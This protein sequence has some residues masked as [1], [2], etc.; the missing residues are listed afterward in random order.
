M[1][2]KLVAWL[3]AGLIVLAIIL[4]FI[5]KNEILLSSIKEN[6]PVCAE[7]ALKI[8]ADPTQKDI[9]G[10]SLIHWAVYSKNPQLV[11]MLIDKKADLNIKD[12]KGGTPLDWAI[13]FGNSDIVK[14]LVENGAEDFRNSVGD[15][16]VLSAALSNKI[17]AMIYLFNKFKVEKSDER[18]L[19][20][21]VVYNSNLEMLKFL[22]KKGLDLSSPNLFLMIRKKT[23]EKRVVEAMK[24][25]L[26]KG[27]DINIAD[28][29]GRTALIESV[30]HEKNEILNFLL[31]KGANTEIKDK[32]D[33]TAL[34]WAK[35]KKNVPATKILTKF[36]EQ[37]NKQL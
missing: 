27:A 24:F 22:D 10:N 34:G 5:F 8:G 14:L 4:P 35:E 23:D 31:K 3:F 18:K 9:A 25:L 13:S 28:S 17:E 26:Q 7:I 37:E 15:T 11:Q 6:R 29:K 19:V 33:K 16:A 12:S 21:H 30:L 32:T 1:K 20:D 36:A 2:F